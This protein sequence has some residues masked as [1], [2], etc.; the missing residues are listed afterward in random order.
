M[1]IDGP[2]AAAVPAPAPHGYAPSPLC[3]VVCMLPFDPSA[4]NAVPPDPRGGGKAST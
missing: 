1:R 2:H 4:K 3:Q